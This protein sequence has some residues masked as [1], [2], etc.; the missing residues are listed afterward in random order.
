M[1]CVTKGKSSLQTQ[2][3]SM[4]LRSCILSLSSELFLSGFLIQ[5]VWFLAPFAVVFSLKSSPEG[6]KKNLFSYSYHVKV[7]HPEISSK[8]IYEQ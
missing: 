1:A 3:T 6:T 4:R 8:W 7:E 2:G 5:E